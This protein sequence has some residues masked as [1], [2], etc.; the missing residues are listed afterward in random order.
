MNFKKLISLFFVLIMLFSVLASCADVDA[1]PSEDEASPE[2]EQPDNAEQKFVFSTMSDYGHHEITLPGDTDL[3]AD[4]TVFPIDDVTLTFYYGVEWYPDIQFQ[5]VMGQFYPYVDLSLIYVSTDYD[6]Y[7]NIG[8]KFEIPIKRVENFMTEEYRCTLTKDETYTEGIRYLKAY[9]H[10]EKLTIPATLFEN[11]DGYIYFKI[12]FS[13]YNFLD[14]NQIWI[15]DTVGFYYVKE[16]D[17]TIKIYR[18]EKE[19]AK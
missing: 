10:S 6:R 14:G 16:P 1:L 2:N 7:N 4:K 9:N 8:E 3:A 11:D 17:N 5:Y 19:A 15:Y 12:Y 13:G 18:S